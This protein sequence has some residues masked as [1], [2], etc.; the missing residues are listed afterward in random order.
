[1]IDAEAAQQESG[2]AHG[3]HRWQQ[4]YDLPELTREWGHLHF[5]LLDELDRYALARPELRAEMLTI[6][7][8]ALAQLSTDGVSRSVAEYAR[9]QQAEAASR[10]RDLET[11]L[12]EV[13][14]LQRQR[15]QDW[16]EAA[17]DLRNQVWLVRSVTA[18]LHH[19]GAPETTTP[20][21]PL[22]TLQKSVAAL[23]ALLNDL[24]S[25]ARLEAGLEERQIAP[26]DAASLMRSLGESSESLAGEAGLRFD[27]TGPAT[28]C[29]D[30]DA[31]KIQRIAQNLLMNALKHTTRGSVQ[32]TWGEWGAAD[33]PR[34]MLEVSNTGAG[35][36]VGAAAPMVRELKD[37][38][39]SVRRVEGKSSGGDPPTASASGPAPTLVGRR[40]S[41][42]RGPGEGIGLSI[43]KR[44]CE[45]L[46]ATL[47]FEQDAEKG[48][49][50]RV[51]FPRR[52]QAA[53]PSG[54]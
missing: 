10:V 29:V 17:H 18:V 49:M 34:W 7:R 54:A 1:M 6:A 24:L 3:A 14:E 53:V 35:S 43:V 13:S 15:A 4:G 25:V 2:A 27:V 30:G 19:L 37:I 8:R 36:E 40:D 16:R 42:L 46:D 39:A 52:Y 11:A 23:S 51:I 31:V 28:L 26:F 44:L 12:S 48:A 45:L 5:C 20:L 38:T 21:K 33:P 32:L 50:F 41:L 47:E 9:L 22:D